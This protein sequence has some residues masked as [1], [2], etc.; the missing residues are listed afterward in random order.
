MALRGEHANLAFADQLM[1]RPQFSLK[2]LLWL[3]VVAAA[4]C[5]G[6]QL[7]RYLKES[8]DPRAIHIHAALDEMTTFAFVEQ[9]LTDVI[10]YLK[11]LHQIEIQL[12]IKALTDAGVSSD[13]PISRTANNIPLHSAL[14]PML[15]NL[16]LTYV[17][18]EGSLMI[19]T[20]TAAQSTLYSL[21]TLMWIA[22]GAAVLL[23]AILFGR[24]W[25]HRLEPLSNSKD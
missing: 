23:G 18:D 3:T 1:R 21:K 4:F 12:D 15:N 11:Q 10:E 16:D 25:G 24:A 20:K 6:T 19:T 7:D 5:A 14:K 22:V 17:V 9:P 13:T 2:T 8:A